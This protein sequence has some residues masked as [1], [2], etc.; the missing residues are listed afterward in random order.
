MRSL[1][2]WLLLSALCAGTALAGCGGSSATGTSSLA[3]TT[4]SERV[5]SVAIEVTIPTLLAEHRI[6]KRYTCDGADASL[7]VQWTGIPRGTAELALFVG[8][9]QPV[10]GG[11]FFDWAVTGLSPKLHGISAG[12]LPPDAVVGRNSFGQD[13]YSICPPRGTRESYAVK[14]IALP[15]KIQAQPGFDALTLYRDAERSAKA[16]GL[17]GVAYKRP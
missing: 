3:K 5:P 15:H 14:V 1:G 10:H 11:L 8:N 16:V 13:R 6:P 4:A 7:P 2:C 9:L 12:R 17:V